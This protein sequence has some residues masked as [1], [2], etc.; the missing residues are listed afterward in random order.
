MKG[1]IARIEEINASGSKFIWTY[2]DG[3]LRQQDIITKEG[4]TTTVKKYTYGE[5]FKT[6]WATEE[7]FN[8]NG[9]L[10]EKREN[11]L[12]D[13]KYA[14]ERKPVKLKKTV[15][16][17]EITLTEKEITNPVFSPAN[18][19]HK[20]D[21]TRISACIHG[22][23]P[24]IFDI[25]AKNRLDTPLL[26]LKEA[27]AGGLGF[28][29]FHWNSINKD[30]VPVGDGYY[31]FK[32]HTPVVRK[33][34]A[35]FSEKK[36]WGR[37]FI[38]ASASKVY[39]Y[40]ANEAKVLVFNPDGD[41]IKEI[42]IASYPMLAKN[43]MEPYS[44]SIVN[45][46]TIYLSISNRLYKYDM[47]GNF[48]SEMEFTVQIPHS[49]YLIFVDDNE[50]IWCVMK[51]SRYQIVN[52]NKTQWDDFTVLRLNNEGKVEELFAE[53]SGYLPCGEPFWNTQP[54]VK[55]NKFYLPVISHL[56]EKEASYYLAVINLD[57]KEMTLIP[58]IHGRVV[59]DVIANE[60]G[61]I[62]LSGSFSM[63]TTNGEG[64]LG[65]NSQSDLWAVQGNHVYSLDVGR[66]ALYCY[67]LESD[68]IIWED[69]LIV[70]N[71][72]PTAEITFPGSDG[73]V[74]GS[75]DQVEII[76]TATDI[77][78]EKYEIYWKPA[79]RKDEKQYWKL[80][81]KSNVPV[82]NGVLAVWNAAESGI[83]NVKNYNLELKIIVTDKA[84]NTI[85]ERFELCYDE[86]NDGFSN[87]FEIANKLD[88]S[89]TTER[90]TA[91]VVP[92]ITTLL[93]RELPING[94]SAL[95]IQLV[96]SQ[97]NEVL[98]NG[99]LKF[100]VN[101]GTVNDKGRISKSE[102]T[103]IASWKT[104]SSV[105]TPATLH[106]EIPPQGINKI[107]YTGEPFE[108]DFRLVIDSDFDGLT[109]EYENKT[110]YGDGKRTSPT[111]PDSDGDGMPDAI[112]LAP[113]YNPPE[114]FTEIYTPGELR[115]KQKY[116]IVSIAGDESYI[117]KTWFKL[118]REMLMDKTINSDSVKK[119]FNDK[120]Y[121]ISSEDRR[122]RSP[123][124]VIDAREIK[125][126]PDQKLTTL[127]YSGT[128]HPTYEFHYTTKEYLYEVDVAN[129]ENTKFPL[130]GYQKYGFLKMATSL[131]WKSDNTI[132][133][134]FTL[135]SPDL[136]QED[137]SAGNATKMFMKYSLYRAGPN[138][139]VKYHEE[140]PFFT[141]FTAVERI[142]YGKYQCFIRIPDAAFDKMWE[143]Y[144]PSD[145]L[146]DSQ[147]II[148]SPVWVKHKGGN[149]KCIV[150][151]HPDIPPDRDEC[152]YYP[153]ICNYRAVRDTFIPVSTANIKLSALLQRCNH[154]AYTTLGRRT[155]RAGKE[156][157][158]YDAIAQ[159]FEHFHPSR[160]ITA[161]FQ[162]GIIP[163][164]LKGKSYDVC[165]YKLFDFREP[166]FNIIAAA[167][168]VVGK[169]SS[170]DAIVIQCNSTSILNCFRKII[171]EKI[172]EK[173]WVGEWVLM[174]TGGSSDDSSSSSVTSISEQGMNEKQKSQEALDTLQSI[175]NKT[176]EFR[177]DAEFIIDIHTE[178][179]N[180]KAD[181]LKNPAI[182]KK[183]EIENE[184]FNFDDEDI[185]S[186]TV[187]NNVEVEKLKNG[188]YQ[189]S[190]YEA[191]TFTFKKGAPEGPK[192]VI[193]KKIKTEEVDDLS[194]SK[195]AQ[196]NNLAFKIP[197][198]TIAAAKIGA[199]LMTDGV[200]LYQAIR[201][202]DGIDI[203][204]YGART[205]GGVGFTL[206]SLK[207][208]DKA[209]FK[210][211][212]LV[213]GVKINAVA[214]VISG[215]DVI[216]NITKAATANTWIERAEYLEKMNAAVVDGVIGCIEPY[217]M[218]ITIGWQVGV[219]ATN[220]L[221][222]KFGIGESSEISKSA[223]SSIG[224]A[225]SFLSK[226]WTLTEIP[227]SIAKDAF[228][229]T[230][231]KGYEKVNDMNKYFDERNSEEPRRIFIAPEL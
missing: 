9:E 166:N 213:K 50:R 230:V 219:F 38:C 176:K 96:D 231:E 205:A 172:S 74:A 137:D 169:L 119:F 201:K 225:Y 3:L 101:A 160:G 80:L 52:G 139:T 84:A 111:N 86:D 191:H 17:E 209:F 195:I 45:D 125:K 124:K 182:W 215:I 175:G 114:S 42:E 144:G 2:Q 26:T 102:K 163:V 62:F 226:H 29:Y 13:P 168:F 106:I 105:V 11:P 183:I 185:T 220:K 56:K 180:F 132:I 188:N 133:V 212:Q 206:A 89:A 69:V 129:H 113:T 4:R 122:E 58:Q 12:L 31:P 34:V 145:N 47:D 59:R 94:E 126:L 202:G 135:G 178:Q 97:T 157:I 77:N 143:L 210:G 73:L 65:F 173:E 48:I 196:K 67:D 150:K 41:L 61:L 87:E 165:Y 57:N 103:A 81:H 222:D 136:W 107:Y 156:E 155:P 63:H 27:E 229:K 204:Y 83:P 197:P 142:D 85:E 99:L 153:N 193:K 227:S 39:V 190:S 1:K 207:W 33:W 214:A 79:Y 121:K 147:T 223:T 93:T 53:I 186:Y 91:K 18:S 217:G 141:G 14:P 104:P 116:H 7:T 28:F 19:P 44:M 164:T 22:T 151:N 194:D 78:F 98:D 171:L 170:A 21:D 30:G 51:E 158:S 140:F 35:Q 75:P 198:E 23:R 115:F 71:T 203:A 152:V 146:P 120:V 218:A 199:I 228:K 37:N 76:G 82:E 25:F 148:M 55:G 211:F 159:I 95:A 224:A 68:K 127:V 70:D 138:Y 161:N 208:S 167:D 216:Y 66:T 187:S 109:D 60:E 134:Q 72:A 43:Q 189:V 221:C 130:D 100:S 32:I 110:Y 8:V 112:D 174:D 128:A 40:Y 117:K 46:S 10:K 5:R 154:Y 108:M 16:D 15:G 64:L 118:G 90:R 162:N 179:I 192:Q 92:H 36:N 49:E 181:E 88:Q 6:I 131:V 24:L 54:F 177:E 184:Q 20:K 149:L 123:L 200:D